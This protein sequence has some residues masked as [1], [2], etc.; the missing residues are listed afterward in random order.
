M[1]A[2]LTGKSPQRFRMTAAASSHTVL[3]LD[4]ALF[5]CLFFTIKQ[6]PVHGKITGPSTELVA[7]LQSQP[8]AGTQR[9]GAGVLTGGVWGT[10]RHGFGPIAM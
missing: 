1:M 9:F 5:V 8:R 7:M 3:G 4:Q 2:S 10:A 6:R